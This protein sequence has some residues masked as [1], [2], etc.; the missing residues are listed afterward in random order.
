MERQSRRKGA[1]R[2]SEIP[3]EVLTALNEGRE[4]TITLVEWFS[5]VCARWM[6]ESPTKETI[7]IV[8]RGLRT[9]RKKQPD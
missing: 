7:W 1:T 3:P 2:R 8:N 5:S 6:D 9:I 4:E